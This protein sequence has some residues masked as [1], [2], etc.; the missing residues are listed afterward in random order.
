MKSWDATKRTDDIARCNTNF[1][2]KWTDAEDKA[3]GMCPTNDGPTEV[4]DR[5]DDH[6]ACVT[7]A[8]APEKVIPSRRRGGSSAEVEDR[9]WSRWIG[10]SRFPLRQ[11]VEFSQKAPR[12][13]VLAT[14]SLYG[15]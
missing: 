13:L 15:Q 1:A 5:I 3:E 14:L 8:L 12:A 6:V 10:N 9:S 7:E 4:G 2:G 11:T